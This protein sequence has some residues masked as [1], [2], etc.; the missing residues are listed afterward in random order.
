MSQI[1]KIEVPTVGVPIVP[2]WRIPKPQTLPTSSHVTLDLGF[3]LIEMPCARL[4]RDYTK[5]KDLFTSDADGVIEV[6]EGA[7]LPSYEPIQYNPQQI[8]YVQEAQPSNPSSETAPTPTTPQP[9]KPKTEAECPGPNQPR[10][11]DLSQSGDEKVSG[12]R[13]SE[14]GETCI[15]LWTPTTFVDKYLPTSTVVTTTTVIAVVAT[16]SA[17][18]SKPLA[19][20]ALKAIKPIV[21]KILARIAK[22][23]GKATLLSDADRR[24]RQR[25]LTGRLLRRREPRAYVRSK[26]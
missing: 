24:K 13:L 2:V 25:E 19:D 21:K 9:E 8:R 20:A 10:V 15:V 3:P 5:N 23:R 26:Y 16:S 11:G 17:I 4:R 1:P 14:D 18:L 12:H 22:L 7:G 6:C